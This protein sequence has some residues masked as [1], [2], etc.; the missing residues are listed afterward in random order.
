MSK[1]SSGARL[2][3]LRYSE[4]EGGDDAWTLDAVEL[5]AINLFVG[6]N[7]AGKTRLLNVMTGLA[8]LVSGEFR[9]LFSS[10][11]YAAEIDVG[12]VRFSYR[13]VMRDSKVALESLR[14]DG[15]ILF[16]RDQ[17]G[18]GRIFAERE[19]QFIQFSV[20]TEL[21]VV[22]SR[23]D[24]LQHPYLEELHR[25]ASS[26]RHYR[27]ANSF[28]PAAHAAL[29]SLM[30]LD[31]AEEKGVEVGRIHEIYTKG[32]GRFGGRFDDAILSDLAL[33][34]YECEEV[35]T[36]QL[37]LPQMKGLPLATLFVK[38]RDILAKT[39]QSKMSQ[40]MF[41]ALSL[42]I[43]LN[44]VL[45]SGGP[46]TVVVDDVGEGL[47]FERSQAMIRLLSSKA[48]EGGWQLIMATNDRF[49]VNSLPLEAIGVVSRQGPYVRVIN[50]RSSPELFQS[51][52]YTGLSNFD[53]FTDRFYESKVH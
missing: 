2:C 12:D 40:G 41:R 46:T 27:F 49:A 1:T 32:Y 5:N 21:L 35:G 48:D 13:L 45:L 23:R 16:D 47:D 28:D 42:V 51:F 37:H 14:R 3:S 30:A 53:F 26:V 29:P 11:D 39:I 19:G 36:E 34:G 22:S 44:Y 9:T 17:E 7:S 24:K 52:R 10:G 4:F 38:E 15:Q 6:R 31:P 50:S 20:P 18:S 43:D 33:L 8:K 25:W